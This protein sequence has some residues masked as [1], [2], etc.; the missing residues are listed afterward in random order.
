MIRPH[1]VNCFTLKHIPGIFN[2]INYWC[3]VTKELIFYVII[4]YF[5]HH[6]LYVFI[7]L[8]KPSIYHGHSAKFIAKRYSFTM[9]DFEFHA[10]TKNKYVHMVLWYLHIYMVAAYHSTS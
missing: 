2:N 9:P 4:F 10:T 7:Y 1:W 3:K 6:L 5:L 8:L